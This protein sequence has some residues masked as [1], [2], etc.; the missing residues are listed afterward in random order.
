MADSRI[1]RIDP[2]IDVHQLHSLCQGENPP[3]LIGVLPAWR[4]GL[5]HIP[6]SRQV[7]RPQLT[8]PD[9]AR[10][11][12][13]AGFQRWVRS[14]GIGPHT[15]VVVWDE[16]YDAARLWWAFHHYGK[17]DVQVLDGRL[18]AWRAAGMPVRRGIGQRRPAHAAAGAFIARAGAGFPVA[19]REQILAARQA[20]DLQLWDTRDLAELAGRRRLRGAHRAGRIPWAQHLNWR[21]FRR[22]APHDNRFRSD[23]ELQALLLEHGLD[24]TKRQIF[25]CQSG[26]R[27]TTAI[28]AL[29][30]LGWDPQQLLNDDASWRQWSRAPEL[31]GLQGDA[32]VELTR[33]PQSRSAIQ[34]P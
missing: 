18:Q 26:V 9:G 12:G 13:A 4:H 27:T 28:L 21:W 16:R 7:W 1:E 10:L 32:E 24:R 14:Q 31:L 11:I 20:E 17:T 29:Y 3:V 33:K 23:D 8:Q 22:N 2:L 25:Y 34:R 5:H 6:G 15:R 30:R 19:Q